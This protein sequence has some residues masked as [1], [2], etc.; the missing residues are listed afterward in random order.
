MNITTISNA[1]DTMTY[2][3]GRWLLDGILI[4]IVVSAFCWLGLLPSVLAHTLQEQH[5]SITDQY[6]GVHAASPCSSQL[7]RT[8]FKTY[9]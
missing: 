8:C 3:L 2:D 9:E 4:V 6:N 7:P 5:I 1:A